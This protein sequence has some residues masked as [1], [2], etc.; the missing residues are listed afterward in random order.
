MSERASECGGVIA[1]QEE[2]RQVSRTSD[3]VCV[4]VCVCLCVC[5]VLCGWVRVCCDGER[6]EAARGRQQRRVAVQII[7]S[8]Y[9]SSSSRT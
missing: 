9:P 5:V 8:E 1:R 2:W 4:C 7:D 6:G 3:G